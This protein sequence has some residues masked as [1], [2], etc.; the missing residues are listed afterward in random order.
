MTKTNIVVQ[1]NE[2]IML[3]RYD[4]TLQEQK[5]FLF[6]VSR[7]NSMKD[8]DFRRI[9]LT[10]QEFATLVGVKNRSS[11]YTSLEMITDKILSRVFRIETEYSVTKFQALSRAK[12]VKKTGTVELTIHQDMM[13]YLLE[14][15]KNFT[16]YELKNIT[17]M[18]S[19][20]ALR[21]YELVKMF[22]RL[23]EVTYD[24][25]N[26]R[27]KLGINA[28]ELTNFSDFNRYV[29]SIARREINSKTD[30]QLEYE[31]I[32]EG[33]KVAL[34]KFK[35]KHINNKK[36]TKSALK[37]ESSQHIRAQNHPIAFGN[38]A[39]QLVENL[40]PN[41]TNGNSLESLQKITHKKNKSKNNISVKTEK[42]IPQKT[43][44]MKMFQ[45]FLEDK[46][47]RFYSIKTN[48]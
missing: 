45:Y 44:F 3:D 1:S 22:E 8:K 25:D 11:I 31:P 15:S 24:I 14:I 46:L 10:V 5:I 21:V 37:L 34:I 9:T 30:L 17:K 35:V 29:L 42:P 47:R 38:I 27:K 26:L 40:K 4:W 23:G 43:G 28:G 41:V 20:Y 18:T 36:I 48:D 6:L 2:L 39:T 12:Y 7:V 32:K 13:P 16:V 33:R 19:S